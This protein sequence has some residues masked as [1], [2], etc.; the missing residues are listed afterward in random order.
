MKSD[1]GEAATELEYIREYLLAAVLDDL[2]E[3]TKNGLVKTFEKELNEAE[4]DKVVNNI[5]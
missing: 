4:I 1:L 3:Q 5:F 2:D